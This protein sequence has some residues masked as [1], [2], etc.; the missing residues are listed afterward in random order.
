MLKDKIKNNGG[1]KETKSLGT[2]KAT[3][4]IGAV[5]TTIKA[6]GII[7][8]TKAIG[9]VIVKEIGVTAIKAI[10]EEITK[11]SGTTT[12]WGQMMEKNADSD[13]QLASHN[14]SI[15]NLEVQ[16][17]QISQTL[18]IHPKGAL[19]SDMVVNS[20]G[21]NNMGHVMVVTTRSEKC[22][23]ATTSNQTRIVDEDVVVQEDEI[24]CNVVQANEEVRIDID[25]SV[26]ETQEEVNPSR[27]HVIDMMELVVPK[28]KAPTP[29]PPPLHPQRLAKQNSENQFKKFIDMIKSL[30]IDVS[31]VKALEQ[32]LG[33]VK[34]MKDLVTKKRSM[35]CESIKMTHQVSDIVHSM[36]PKLEDLG[37]LTIPCTIGSTDFAKALCDIGAM[38]YEVPIILGRYFLAT[39]KALIDVEAG[40]LTF[41]MDDE[42]V[43]F[44]V[45]KSMRQ[46]NRNEVYSFVDLVTDVIVDDAIATMNVED[47][48]EV[49]LLNLD[50][51][52]ESDGYVKCV[53]ALQGMGSYTYEPRKLSLDLENRKTPLT[54]PLPMHQGASHLGV[55]AIAPASQEKCHF[56]V[57]EGIVLYHKI[58]KHGIEVNKAKIEDFS[59]V[60][61]PFCK[62]LEKDAKFH[63]YEDCNKAFKFLNFKLTTTLI[64][65]TSDWSLPFELM[66]DASDVA[67]AAGL[68]KRINKIFHLAYYASKTMNDAQVN[69]T[70]TEKEL[71]AIVFAMEK[72]RPYL[73]GT[74]VIVLTDHAA[75]GI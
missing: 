12:T 3:K 36:A 72:F 15:R 18:N 35:N 43:V 14:T 5:E 63:F 46:P 49:I 23:D 20:K 65:T 16:L 38:D 50:D 22:G 19:P 62:L 29:R 41:R 37:A 51:N 52:K 70:V 30:S 39:G 21:G 27:E 59:K 10:G 32:M 31:F 8:V 68:G 48:S 55:K 56:M 24:P 7:K 67:D 17:G 47:K 69:Y 75:L 54:K 40:E 61:N 71:L 60:V 34:F 9:E 4:E 1:R 25:E 33:Y 53:N 64:I 74:K 6:I 73:M 42:K 11:E 66:R 58:S 45:C 57:K 44:H 26:E 28:A 2:T 13:A